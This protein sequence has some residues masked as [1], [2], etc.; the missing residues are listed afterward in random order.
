[1][2]HYTVFQESV[3]ITNFHSEVF[4]H[5][6]N[7]W[8]WLIFEPDFLN[9]SWMDMLTIKPKLRCDIEGSHMYGPKVF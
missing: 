9:T 4:D 8:L 7:N 5:E 6:K 2:Y 1:M 3:F